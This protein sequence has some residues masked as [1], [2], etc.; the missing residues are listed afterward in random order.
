MNYLWNTTI[1]KTHFDWYT[2]GRVVRSRFI[3]SNVQFC[4]KYVQGQI[5]A[6]GGMRTFEN[7]YLLMVNQWDE[8][9]SETSNRKIVHNRLID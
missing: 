3:F 1:W 8:K 5:I 6:E 7:N 2:W 9:I 4:K